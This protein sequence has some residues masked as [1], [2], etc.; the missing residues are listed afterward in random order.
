MFTILINRKL[1][2]SWYHVL[3]AVTTVC[4]W[5]KFIKFAWDN[6][7]KDLTFTYVP[8]WDNICFRHENTFGSYFRRKINFSWG[9]TLESQLCTLSQW[10]QRFFIQI[11]CP[12][13]LKVYF[14]SDTI[15]DTRKTIL[16][17]HTS[18]HESPQP[19]ISVDFSHDGKVKFFRSCRNDFRTPILSEILLR[20]IWL[21]VINSINLMAWELLK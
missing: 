7:F 16:K 17:V 5:R 4:Q 9:K 2:Y 13:G 6:F 1:L 3:F 12:K 21:I 11:V 14:Y 19:P 8:A 10:G 18:W 15:P 20:I